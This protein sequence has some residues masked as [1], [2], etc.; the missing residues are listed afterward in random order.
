MAPTTTLDRLS[1]EL[2]RRRILRPRAEAIVNKFAFWGAVGGVIPIPL[3][4]WTAVSGIQVWMIK[5]LCDLYDVQFSDAIARSIVTSL[6]GG[7]VPSAVKTIPGIGWILGL[8]TAP[9]AFSAATWG[10]GKIIISHFERG[11]G[12]HDLD[13]VEAKQEMKTSTGKVPAAEPLT[14]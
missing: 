5:E 13:P 12:I 2:A 4:D 1:Q 14:T 9:A 10:V 8:A 11:G 3:L 6:L 7:I